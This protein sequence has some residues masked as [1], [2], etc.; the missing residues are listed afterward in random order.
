MTNYIT[1]AEFTSVTGVTWEEAGENGSSSTTI[2]DTRITEAQKEFET[3]VQKTFDGTENDYALAQR[4]VA[5]LSAHLLRMRQVKIVPSSKEEL[6]EASSVYYYEYQRLVRLMKEGETADI[7]DS[8][9]PV[10]TG[11][12]ETVQM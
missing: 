4:A 12:F 5:F 3:E 7:K 2:R 1:A 9:Q 8:E 6:E 11:G 10:W